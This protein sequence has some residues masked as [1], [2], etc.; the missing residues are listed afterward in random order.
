M[1]E[2]EPLGL[3]GNAPEMPNLPLCLTFTP[4]NAPDIELIKK[5]LGGKALSLRAPD[6]AIV[7]FR[8]TPKH[9]S[10]ENLTASAIAGRGIDGPAIIILAEDT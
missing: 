7:Y 10:P 4:A 5:T 8:S 2:R 9:G 3:V 6:G 1:D